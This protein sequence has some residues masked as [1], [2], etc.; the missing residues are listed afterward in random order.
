MM[1]DVISL[2]HKAT[3]RLVC[4]YMFVYIIFPIAAVVQ[5]VDVANWMGAVNVISMKNPGLLHARPGLLVLLN[6]S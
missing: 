2:S 3:S 5:T 1:E 4:D 6:L